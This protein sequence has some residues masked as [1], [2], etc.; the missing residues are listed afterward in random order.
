[1]EKQWEENQDTAVEQTAPEALVTKEAP[2]ADAPAAREAAAAIEDTLDQI[3]QSVQSVTE[4]IRETEDS[5]APAEDIEVA[6][7][8]GMNEVPAEGAP[9][10]D[11]PAETPVEVA[12]DAEPSIAV[13]PEDAP[14]AESPAAVPDAAE[15]MSA[16][17]DESVPDAP[18]APAGYSRFLVVHHDRDGKNAE[19]YRAIRTSLFARYGED[20]ISLVVTSA[21]PG[22][23]KT[24]TSLNLGLVLAERRDRRTVVVDLDL[25]HNR[26]A[27]L[28]GTSASP[29]VADVLSGRADLAD[30][31]QP[32]EYPNLFFIP[33]GRMDGHPAGELLGRA[34]LKAMMDRLRDDYDYALFDTP[35]VNWYS[36]AGVAGLAAG[37]ALLVVRLN[38][39]PQEKVEQAI[40]QLRTANVAVVGMVMTHGKRR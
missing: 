18:A 8:A 25:R 24:V 21:E 40:R 33:G 28:L 39:T 22:E 19:E 15:P 31:I 27:Q 30:I 4:L 2:E 10:T 6:E 17:T 35:A 7:P 14:N 12:T 3:T 11:A 38:K 32:T 1:M 37:E 20:R 13:L 36:D 9:V 23:G 34:E 16:V 26:M 5:S 29:G